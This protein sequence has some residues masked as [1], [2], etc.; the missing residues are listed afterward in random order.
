MH[1]IAGVEPAHVVVGGAVDTGAAGAL[2]HGLI[3]ESPTRITRCDCDASS[4]AQSRA[5]ISA[6]RDVIL[7]LNIDI[8]MLTDELKSSCTFFFNE[9]PRGGAKIHKQTVHNRPNKF[10]YACRFAVVIS[11]AH[12]VPG[13]VEV[14]FFI[15]KYNG[16]LV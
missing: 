9:F 4:R 10:C 2:F 8:A 11:S 14:V 5:A 15:K 3:Q 12:V 13:V 7:S 16:Y 1:T 6:Q